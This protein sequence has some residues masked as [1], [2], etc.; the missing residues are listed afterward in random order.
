[1][2]SSSRRLL[3]RAA[4]LALV[5]AS[6][7]LPLAGSAQTDPPAKT[8]RKGDAIALLSVSLNTLRLITVTQVEVTRDPEGSQKSGSAYRLTPVS[9][10]P[11]LDTVLLAGKLPPGNYEVTLVNDAFSQRNVTLN[12]V[13]RQ[14][15]G[16]FAVA[17]GQ[18]VDLG[19]LVVTA[20]NQRLLVGRSR[21][22]SRNVELLRALDPERAAD[23]VS[24]PVV[25]GWLAAPTEVDITESYG[26]GRPLGARS[27][28]EAADGRIVVASRLGSL[29]VR[30]RDGQWSVLNSDRQEALHYAAPVDLPDAVT[31]AVGDHSVILRQ[32]LG[33]RALVAVDSG[34]LAPGRLFFIAGNAKVGWYLAQHTGKKVRILHA[35]ALSG[36]NWSVIREEEGASTWRTGPSQPWFWPTANGF[37]YAS[38]RG[39]IHAFDFTAGQW[40]QRAS[41]L[42]APFLNVVSNGDGSVGALTLST[43]GLG[44]PHARSFISKDGAATWQELTP[45][46]KGSDIAPV[47]LANG[48]LLLPGG[49]VDKAVLQASSDGGATWAPRGEIEKTSLLRA[50]P[51]GLLLMVANHPLGFFSIDVSKDGGQTW[52]H[53]LSHFDRGIYELEKE[54]EK[55]KAEDKKP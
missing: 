28:V 9:T 46:L 41:P 21:L 51:S 13:S 24:Q 39:Q 34:N 19:R 12:P 36:G 33:A 37:A 49:G 6:L 15:T 18:S 5:W 44:G 14:A 55:A 31:L 8:T 30:S 20:A 2:T 11:S 23:F 7:W 40:T 50:M 48:T 17:E 10:G 35:M 38:L 26:L 45:E 53:E 42:P 43:S 52:R 22:P 27:I 1:M 54:R 47:V 32:P 25:P 3:G 16:R 29:H 4:A